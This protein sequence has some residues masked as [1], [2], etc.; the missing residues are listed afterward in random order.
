MLDE[1][2]SHGEG[3][4]ARAIVQRVL[5]RHLHA[6]AGAAY[7][8][9]F[10]IRPATSRRSLWF[11]HLSQHPTARDVMLT[12]HWREA[13]SFLHQG[14]GGLDML[15]YDSVIEG[16]LFD[17]MF[18]ASAARETVAQ[19]LDQLP[20]AVARLAPDEPV[21]VDAFHREVANSTAATREM[22]DAALLELRG[23]K[24]VRLLRPSGKDLSGAAQRLTSTDL[25]VLP[26]MPA[27]P[28]LLRRPRGR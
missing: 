22:V 27:F 28:R 14:Q 24:E 2:I 16:T 15:G 4:E 26:E 11:V 10:Y 23:A 9:P 17:F 12:Q 7:Y 21:T 13:N 25:V 19:L 18:D 5:S 20:G 8:T 1:M 3:R 6:R